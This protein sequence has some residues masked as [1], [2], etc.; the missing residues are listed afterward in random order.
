VFA[1]DNYSVPYNGYFDVIVMNR[2]GS[3]PT[4]LTDRSGSTKAVWSPDGTKIAY[5][6]DGS[7]PA[8][9]RVM[10]SD[11]S[12]DHAILA[13]PNIEGLDS[14]DWQ[15]VPAKGYIRPKTAT[16]TR[17]SLT[18]AYKPCTASNET[19]GPPLGFASCSPPQQAS[20]YLTIG[21]PDANGQQAQSSG[22][23]RYGWVGEIPIDPNNGNQA[24]VTIDFSL[25]DVRNKSD[26]SDY[27]G[28]LRATTALRI[29][30][31]NN[32]PNPGGPGPATVTDT[33][34]AV[35]IPCVGTASAI[36]GSAC[37]PST[38]E[39]ALV[40]GAVIEGKRAVWALGQVQVYDGGADGDADTTGDNTLFEDEGVFI[41]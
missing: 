2:D 13:D 19:H 30:D 28:E 1:S 15:P 10:N 12:G 35:T 21:T 6:G 27:G 4:M 26:L 22:Y 38:T 41:P 36:F 8:E 3:T 31:K 18:P 23:V 20:D 40:P 5:V 34:L 11:G 14:L 32:T 25:T 16:P 33:T 7:N 39:N 29:T 9:I 24:D 37:G 17:I